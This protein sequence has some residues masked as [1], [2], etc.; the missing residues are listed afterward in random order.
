M[1]Q[2]LLCWL[3]PLVLSVTAAVAA[4]MERGV[5][6]T[7]PHV[8]QRLDES[9]LSLGQLLGADANAASTDL[10]ALPSMAK[11]RKQPIAISIL[12]LSVTGT[13]AMRCICSTAMR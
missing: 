11:A 10:I 7:D 2:N 9:G 8:L 1:V 3:L 13:S 6:I 12:T 5:A 4:P